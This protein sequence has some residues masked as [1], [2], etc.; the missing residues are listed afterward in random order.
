MERFYYYLYGKQFELVTDHK[1]LEVIF[2]PKSKPCARI[3][4]WI[5]R[6][7]SYRF[8]VIYKPGKTNIADPLSRLIADTNEKPTENGT[9]TDSTEYYVNWVVENAT[10]IA[11]TMREIEEAS[12]EDDTIN[13]ID[14]NVWPHSI[15]HY[16]LFETEFC[17]SGN[18]LLRGTRIVMPENL[19]ERTLQLAHEGHPGIVVMKR[20]LR[21][22]VW[23]SKMDAEAYVKKCRGCTLVGA[24]PAPE[25][26]K[27]T[28]LPSRAWEHIAIDF[29]GPLPSGHWLFVIVD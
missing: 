29:S 13:A 21:T 23:W 19:Q 14:K 2:S 18:I 22:K 3:E 17:F 20:R 15:Q 10:P 11:I 4:R 8:K 28:E 1:P 26:M 7:Q 5:L 12:A 9:F 6:I 16:K 27:R 25:P 24:P